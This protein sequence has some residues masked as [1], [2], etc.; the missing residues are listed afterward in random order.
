ME[1]IKTLVDTP[2]DFR[3]GWTFGSLKQQHVPSSP[4]L[5]KKLKC[6]VIQKEIGHFA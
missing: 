1:K 2:V 6:N 5:S 3:W 4:V